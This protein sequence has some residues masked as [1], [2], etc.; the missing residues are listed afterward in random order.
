MVWKKVKVVLLYKGPFKLVEHPNSYKPI[1]LLDGNGKILERLVLNRV[2][3][4]IPEALAFSQF[5]FRPSRGTMEFIEVVLGTAT[6]AAK[7]MVLNRHQCILVTLDVKN[8]FNSA[9]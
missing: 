6:D 4:Q 5:G 1:S 2:A 7:G 8:A 9:P 3:Q